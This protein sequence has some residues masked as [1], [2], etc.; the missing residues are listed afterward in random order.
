MNNLV[1]MNR[2]CMS[3]IK[4]ININRHTHTHTHTHPHPH[5]RDKIKQKQSNYDIREQQKYVEHEMKDMGFCFSCKQ[6]L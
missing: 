6:K 5:K 2:E 1:D 3:E 4:E